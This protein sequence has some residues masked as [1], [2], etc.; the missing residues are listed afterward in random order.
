MMTPPFSMRARPALTWK[1]LSWPSAAAPVPLVVG[2]SE[3]IVLAVV[4]DVLCESG[5]NWGTKTKEEREYMQ[6]KKVYLRRERV[7]TVSH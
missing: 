7:G 1:L 5:E 2:S 6:L 3:A 4:V